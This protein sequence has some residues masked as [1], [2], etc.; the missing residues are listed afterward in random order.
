MRP[1]NR[2]G[3]HVGAGLGEPGRFE[4]L[5]SPCADVDESVLR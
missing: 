1:V 3:R 5:G 4:G 2:D